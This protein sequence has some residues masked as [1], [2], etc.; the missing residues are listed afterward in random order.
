MNAEKI[1]KAEKLLAEL[2]RLKAAVQAGKDAERIAEDVGAELKSVLGP[3]TKVDPDW[4][5]DWLTHWSE[6]DFNSWNESVAELIESL[7]LK[8]S[9][10]AKLSKAERKILGY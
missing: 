1:K 8:A 2:S 10:L 4:G 6:T 7:K 3:V 5:S 9:V